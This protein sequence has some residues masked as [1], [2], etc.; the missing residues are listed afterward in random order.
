MSALANAFEAAGYKS[1]EEQLALIAKRVVQMPAS[2]YHEPLNDFDHD[3]QQRRLL[4]VAKAS[5][6]ASP[7]NWDG[8][9]DEFYKRVR[10][11]ATLLWTLF[12]PY[13]AQAAQQML[14]QASQELRDAGLA[15][16]S[17]KDAGGQSSSED[18]ERHA[19]S[20]PTT[21]QKRQAME[22]RSNVAKLSMLDTFKVNGQPIGDLTPTEA[23]KWAG[24]RERDARFVRM[25]TQ[26]LPPDQ[27]IRKYR[28]DADE[29][30]AFYA[31]ANE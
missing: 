5:V 2:N 4:E 31:K 15:A 30:A 6:Q 17:K 26:N 7:R 22:V 20:A 3:T 18:Q 19:P 24:A 1:V 12:A 28:T 13:R 14:T 9:K 23:N 11:D 21:A 8:A 29:V 25:L 16:R 10:N 27:P